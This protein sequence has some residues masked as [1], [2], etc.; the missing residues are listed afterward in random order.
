MN[1]HYKKTKQLSDEAVR[2]MRTVTIVIA[3]PLLLIICA[4]ALGM[5]GVAFSDARYAFMLLFGGI[6]L[7]AVGM[8]AIVVYDYWTV[9]KG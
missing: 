2:Q 3:A 4:L 6:A 1:R 9:S 7:V 5:A 8:L